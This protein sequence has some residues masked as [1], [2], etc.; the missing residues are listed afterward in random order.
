MTIPP[1]PPI[2]GTVSYYVCGQFS[3][4]GSGLC[5]D[6]AGNPLPSDIALGSGSVGGGGVAGPSQLFKP[7]VAGF[8]CFL[9]V[10]S[11]DSNY[12]GSSDNGSNECFQAKAVPPVL[13]S[14]V[15]LDDTV[16]I[17][18]DATAGQP[19]G[20]VTFDL[21]GPFTS[22]DAVS[23]ATTNVV[24]GSE[25]TIPA[26]SETFD[27][28]GNGYWT[29]NE[30]IPATG[31]GSVWYAWGASFTATNTNY[32]DGSLGCTAEEVNVNYGPGSGF[33]PPG[34]VHFS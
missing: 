29:V 30:D 27:T 16:S 9:G 31:S 26:A 32:M 11:G 22:Q 6:S 19:S 7:T 34:N 25:Q 4:P 8:Y 18:K 24:S 15:A 17:Q 21:F 10:Y 28:S 5:V 12:L 23:C 1:F 3:A 13:A 2:T 33:S 20:N 14:T